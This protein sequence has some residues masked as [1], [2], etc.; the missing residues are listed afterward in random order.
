ML[1]PWGVHTYHFHFHFFKHCLHLVPTE[2]QY[3]CDRDSASRYYCTHALPKQWPLPS[4][5]HGIMRA[6]MLASTTRLERLSDYRTV[7]CYQPREYLAQNESERVPPVSQTLIRLANPPITLWPP[8]RRQAICCHCT[9]PMHPTPM[10]A[11]RNP[12]CEPHRCCHVA[13][14]CCLY[15]LL[16]AQQSLRSAM[17]SQVLSSVTTGRSCQHPRQ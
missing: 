14:M 13:C 12:Q 9:L 11:G 15:D 3:T 10:M 4:P 2:L 17:T 6:S 5:Q 7:A 16:W 1:V 8:R